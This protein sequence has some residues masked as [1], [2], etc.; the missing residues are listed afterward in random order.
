M[1]GSAVGRLP[2]RGRE[3]RH[4]TE[5]MQVV[6]TIL[7]VDDEPDM[8]LLLRMALESAGHRVLD[9]RDGAAALQTLD[10]AIP[11]I[12]ITD[13]R[14]PVMDGHELIERLRADPRT[15]AVPVVVVTANPT[16]EAGGDA[17]IRKPFRPR[18]LLDLVD[19][20][21]GR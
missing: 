1:S 5:A 3:G 4:G 19:G 13:L 8:L 7:I 6:A 20:L 18:E 11:D 9:A 14:M 2:G 17:L 12:V 16:E 21:L 10:E 15:A